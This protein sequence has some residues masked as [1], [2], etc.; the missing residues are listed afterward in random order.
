[1]SNFNEAEIARLIET[2]KSMKPTQDKY[3]NAV[4]IPAG[5]SFAK[6]VVDLS[7]AGEY[8]RTVNFF[9]KWM[10]LQHEVSLYTR[11]IDLLVENLKKQIPP[12][13]KISIEK[14]GENVEKNGEAHE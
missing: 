4:K 5:E 10:D 9:T 2:L 1:M 11:E 12:L 3:T 14:S 7:L 8:E 6:I 13:Q